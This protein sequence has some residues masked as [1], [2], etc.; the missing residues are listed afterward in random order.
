MF[1]IKCGVLYALL[2]SVSPV[3]FYLIWTI[4]LLEG[5]VALK[6]PVGGSKYVTVTVYHALLCTAVPSRT[7][8]QG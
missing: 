2:V 7:G 4:M 6:F 3:S 1:V 5:L 8:S